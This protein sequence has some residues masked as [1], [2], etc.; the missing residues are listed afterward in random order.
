MKELRYIEAPV[1]YSGWLVFLV[2]LDGVPKLGCNSP[3]AREVSAMS[4]TM[5]FAVHIHFVGQTDLAH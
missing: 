5:I 1:N 4:E 2:E 3:P